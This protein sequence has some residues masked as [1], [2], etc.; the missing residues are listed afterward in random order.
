MMLAA[1]AP[2]GLAQDCVMGPEMDAATRASMEN[3]GQQFFSM[4]ASGNAAG[5]QAAAIPSFNNAAALLNENKANLSGATARTRWVYLLDNS[6]AKPGEPAEFYCGI[7]NS[8]ERIGFQFG[9]IPAGKYGVVV[10]DA[11]G[12]KLPY[13]VTWVLMQNGTQWK[14]AGMFAKPTELAGHDGLWYWKQARAYLSAGKKHDAFFYYYVA[15]LLLRP[16]GAMTTPNLDKLG[17]EMMKADP[18]DLPTNGPV[19]LNAGN[20]TYQ[21]TQM[22]PVPVADDLDLVVKYSVPSVGDTNQ[23]LQDNTAVIRAL[24]ARY[25][26]LREAFTAMIARAT[27]PNGQDYGTL[28]A[29]KDVK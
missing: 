5:L 23:A 17:D 21:L 9:Q 10:Q 16:F 24:L 12:G 13:M 15:D 26:E 22:F 7:F 8:P 11:G 1:A 25:P 19:P 29:M 4:L 2:R 3:A 14:A 18:G 28:L 6:K 20:R 27:A